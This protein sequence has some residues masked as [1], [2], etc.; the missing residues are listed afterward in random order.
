MRE[1]KAVYDDDKKTVMVL[2]NTPF[3]KTGL[4]DALHGVCMFNGGPTFV[5]STQDERGQG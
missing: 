4:V 5:P 2:T 3:H 1:A